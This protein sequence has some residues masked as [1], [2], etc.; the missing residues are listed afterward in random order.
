M[1]IAAPHGVT[2]C[3]VFRNPLPYEFSVVQYVSAQLI[4]R[5]QQF[6]VFSLNVFAY[7]QHEIIYLPLVGHHHLLIFE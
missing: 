7:F 2:V 3:K 1:C 5:D 6:C 4:K